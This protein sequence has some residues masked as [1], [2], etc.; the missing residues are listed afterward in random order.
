MIKLN[1]IRYAFICIDKDARLAR[2]GRNG[3]YIAI[4][5]VRFFLDRRVADFREDIKELG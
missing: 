3:C 2:I 4:S 5:H 1:S